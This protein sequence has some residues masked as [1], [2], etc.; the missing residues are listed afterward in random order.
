[1]YCKQRSLYGNFQIISN[2]NP[3]HP[4]QPSG[5]RPSGWY[6]CLGLIWGM[7]WKLPYHNIF[8]IHFSFWQVYLCDIVCGVKGKTAESS[9]CSDLGF[10]PWQKSRITHVTGWYVFF[11]PGKKSSITHM[12]HYHTFC[13]AQEWYCLKAMLVSHL[14]NEHIF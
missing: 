12:T 1:M 11:C 6:G 7:M 8:I 4:Y 9:E 13:T 5:L 10:L 2:I 3:R 14:Q